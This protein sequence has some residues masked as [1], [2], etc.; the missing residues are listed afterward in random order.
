[1]RRETRPEE[2][3]RLQKRTDELKRQHADLALDTTPFNKADHDKH[4]ADLRQHHRDL[5]EHKQRK[6]IAEST[7]HSQVRRHLA[8]S[9]HVQASK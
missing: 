1:V 4:T 8:R 3:E 7:T 6:N 5:E 2:H 9:R